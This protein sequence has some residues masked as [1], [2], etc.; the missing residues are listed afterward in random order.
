[1]CATRRVFIVVSADCIVDCSFWVVDQ[2][3][4]PGGVCVVTVT[5]KFYYSFVYN[6]PKLFYSFIYGH[7]QFLYSF[8]CVVHILL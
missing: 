1:M 4:M 2:A 7:I 3:G 6:T 8:V 5:R